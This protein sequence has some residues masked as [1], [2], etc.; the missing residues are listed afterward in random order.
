MHVVSHRLADA[1][2]RLAVTGERTRP[3]YALPNAPPTPDPDVFDL[4]R[5][6]RT[7]LPT[8]RERARAEATR[9]G[10]QLPVIGSKGKV[11]GR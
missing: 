5:R 1:V 2:G 4:R 9:R 3:A 10:R 7:A 8:E 11:K 6:R